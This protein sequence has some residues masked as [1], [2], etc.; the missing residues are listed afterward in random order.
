M[1]WPWN[2]CFITLS[3]VIVSIKTYLTH[4]CF[5]IRYIKEKNIGH[6]LS[7]TI[8]ESCD[9]NSFVG[10]DRQTN[11]FSRF[12]T[13]VKLGCAV[14]SSPRVSASQCSSE[15]YKWI[16]EGHLSTQSIQEA[17]RTAMA[18]TWVIST[19]SLPA[20][21]PRPRLHAAFLHLQCANRPF[22]P[23]VSE[24][25]ICGCV[26]KKEILYLIIYS[27]KWNFYYYYYYV[28]FKNIWKFRKNSNVFRKIDEF[29]S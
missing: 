4:K 9:K 18:T 13:V 20:P 17:S 3:H 16:I 21:R 22:W 1:P 24:Y 15:G 8:E 5:R 28:I 25:T 7:L 10:I 6:F 12:R 19:V 2:R 26:K 14:P 11:I 23:L 29:I 27:Q